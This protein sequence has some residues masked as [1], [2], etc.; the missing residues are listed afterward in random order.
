MDMLTEFVD[1]LAAEAE[2]TT[3]ASVVA[4]VFIPYTGR[5][6]QR[7]NRCAEMERAGSGQSV[8]ARSIHTQHEASF[9]L[10]LQTADGFCYRVLACRV[11][12]KELLQNPYMLEDKNRRLYVR[13]TGLEKSMN[14]FFIRIFVQGR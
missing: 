6:R 5:F 7:R 14:F 4:G 1:Q 13:P 8:S 11:L 2:A 12:T 9:V 3:T 10:S